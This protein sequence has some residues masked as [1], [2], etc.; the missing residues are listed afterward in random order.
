MNP[1]TWLRISYWAGAVA[2]VVIGVLT[3]IPERMG[4]T[5]FRYPM[6]LAAALMFA[7]AVLL[8]WADRKPA[9]RKGILLITVFPAIVGLMVSGTWAVARGL[10]P[11]ARTI[12]SAI[13]GV[14]LIALM[15]YSYVNAR[16]LSTSDEAEP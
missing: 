12:P 1:V 11:L 5:E 6:G 9:E 4:E 15:L 7:W 10:V 3:L 16:H 8:L 13:L 14:G 2:D